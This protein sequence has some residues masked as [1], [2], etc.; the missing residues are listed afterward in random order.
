[1]QAASRMTMTAFG[2][3]RAASLDSCLALRLE[4]DVLAALRA[5]GRGRQTR[6]NDLLARRC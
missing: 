5:T 4:R 2:R 6:I 1:M 3:V